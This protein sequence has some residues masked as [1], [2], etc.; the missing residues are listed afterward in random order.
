M[1]KK[2]SLEYVNPRSHAEILECI[3]DSNDKVVENK[4]RDCLA[5]SLRCD[6]SVD[7]TNIDKIYV[8]ARIANKHGDL[9]TVFIGVGEKTERKTDGL[10]DAVKK[11]INAQ[12]P[13]L[14]QPIM[15]KMSSFVTDGA[16]ENIGSSKDLLNNP[17]SVINDRASNLWKAIDSEVAASGSLLK[18]QKIWCAAH[19]SEL[20]WKCVSKQ[21][22][23]LQEIFTKLT[24]ISSHF[25]VSA[26]RFAQLKNI[27]RINN[28]KLLAFPKVFEIRWSQFTYAL[29]HAVLISW[30]CLVKYFEE[31]QENV[32]ILNFLQNFKK[33]QLLAFIADVLFIF[34]RFQKK[35]QADDLNMI[36]LHHHVQNLCSAIRELESQPM[37]GGWELSLKNSIETEEV[38]N[39]DGRLKLIKL[40]DIY[41]SVEELERRGAHNKKRQFETVRADIL[42]ELIDFVKHYMKVDDNFVR[43]ITPFVNL[44]VENVNMTE[45]HQLLAPDLDI[46]SL[47]LQ[48]R[49][50]CTCNEL[51]Q[52]SLTQLT[53]HLA[54]NDKTFSY[55]DVLTVLARISAATPHSADAERC[56]SANNLLKTPLRNSVNL[57]TENNYLNVHYNMPTLTEWDARE[58]VI[59]WIRKKDRRETNT[60]VENVEKNQRHFVGV[61]PEAKK[62]KLDD[63]ENLSEAEYLQAEALK[64]AKKRKF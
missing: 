6:G 8:L 19:R 45:V 10:F 52:L 31:T 26:L 50:L 13:N 27:A 54:K 55:V 44:D 36:S 16:P 20:S 49:E 57:K 37:L 34:Q 48:F 18:L 43:I 28:L 4:I 59:N 11:A 1:Q 58:A 42:K 35:I 40:K 30:H 22:K 5:L 53:S 32:G 41:L 47:S 24:E 56:I 61:F 2:I 25:H 21:I 46:S 17:S 3:V 14:Y 38:E 9:E 12:N 64:M 51:R 7:R 39:E 23:E 33:L 29:V 62:R 63:H 15:K 60:T